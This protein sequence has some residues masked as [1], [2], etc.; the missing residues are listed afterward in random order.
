MPTK[1]EMELS[2]KYKNSPNKELLCKVC[3][4]NL[5]EVGP[6]V[7][8]V[9][10]SSCVAKMVAPP[11]TTTKPIPDEKRPRGWH[12]RAEYVSPSGKKYAFGKEVS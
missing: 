10:C 7:E 12:L 11:E 6:D 8:A 9:T 2:T 4:D 3:S 1:R 5:V